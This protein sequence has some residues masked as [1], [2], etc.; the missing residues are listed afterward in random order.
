[1][2]RCSRLGEGGKST[3]A[4]QSWWR[5]QRSSG[6]YRPGSRR[7]ILTRARSVEPCQLP[8]RI[9]RRSCESQASQESPERHGFANDSHGHA[10]ERKQRRGSQAVSL[11]LFQ[12]RPRLPGIP[13]LLKLRLS[14]L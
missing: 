5:P 6:R 11:S 10:S 14:L 2:Y 4:G 8:R 13:A 1:M 7:A 3:A 9:E 12:L